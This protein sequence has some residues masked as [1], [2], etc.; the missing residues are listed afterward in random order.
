MQ[1]LPAL[2]SIYV[3]Y[4]AGCFRFNITPQPSLKICKRADCVKKV[5][6]IAQIILQGNGISILKE[7]PTE[8]YQGS[9][10]PSQ[11][12]SLVAQ[13]IKS[14]DF[15]LPILVNLINFI[16]IERKTLS[17]ILNKIAKKNL[18]D[19]LVKTRALY[20]SCNQITQEII[21]Q[22]IAI[23]LQ[24]DEVFAMDSNTE[25][26]HVCNDCHQINISPISILNLMEC[27]TPDC[28]GKL[29]RV[30]RLIMLKSKQPL[31]LD[32]TQHPC[33]ANI[34][35][36]PKAPSAA[37]EGQTSPPP[38]ASPTCAA[39][40]FPVEETLAI[41]A[42]TSECIDA[43]NY[44]STKTQ[45]NISRLKSTYEL[46]KQM[47]EGK[48]LIFLENIGLLQILFQK[49]ITTLLNASTESST[50]IHSTIQLE[51]VNIT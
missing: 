30:V 31:I 8:L 4:C 43:I 13:A 11:F 24:I 3:Y 2:E 22:L 49:M 25:F 36:H 6:K 26:L 9:L 12:P 44:I 21:D 34:T 45:Q 16:S 32:E 23:D 14:I 48:R 37:C 50:L 38:A 17:V 41:E 40:C 39:V 29:L 10:H 27:S 1:P 42:L 5:N 19:L 47:P 35:M 33:N 46:L 7:N 28:E 51:W 18:T 15:T 20:A